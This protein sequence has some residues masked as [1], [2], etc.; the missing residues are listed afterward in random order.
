MDLPT[1]NLVGP[2]RLGRSLARLWA[3]AGLVRV[4][5]VLGRDPAN[6]RAACAFIGAGTPHA[7]GEALPP[8]GLWLL[9]TPDDALADT[10]RALAAAGALRPADVAFHCSGALASAVLAPLRARGALL[11]G[12][13]PLKSFADP[14]AAIAGF[15][16]TFCA[17]EGDPAA[18]AALAPL[19]DA[20][21][22]R[23]FDV[24]P[25]H[26]IL[27]HA[28][29]VLACNHLVALID[30][31]LRCMEGAGVGR[32]T[33]WAALLPL[34]EGTLANIGR[35]GT[36]GA[37]TGPVARGDR[38]TVCAEI[39]ATG[40]VDVDI[41]AAYR[42]LSLLALRLAPAATGLSREDIETAG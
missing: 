12:V 6:T 25:A 24:E 23:R 33:G 35:G 34:V 19:F 36:A 26:K 28:A 5:A 20:I 15:A 37:L 9:A 2:G 39:A 10:A 29:A 30:A 17:C 8:A 22:A 4:G 21:G 11:A 41:G 1:L 40:A 7:P 31:A 3:D 32:D 14:A 27:Y 16:G 42:V 13:H 38:A 18:L